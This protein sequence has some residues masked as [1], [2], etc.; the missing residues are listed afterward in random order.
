MKIM[1][2]C[3]VVV[4]IVWLT[5]TAAQAAEKGSVFRTET[6]GSALE[7]AGTEGKLVLIDF[8]TTWCGPCKML[9]QMTWPDPR[10]IDLLGTKTVP[11]K[12]DAEKE[13]E[14]AK[15]YKVDAYPTV[16]FLKP[17]GTEVDRLI[18]YRDPA[19]FIEEFT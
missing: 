12:I 11:L 13:A 1:R 15:R 19:K 14:L 9:D 17:D 7:E 4:G 16:L 10:V 6:F 5:S 2:G 8:F 3:F 18:G